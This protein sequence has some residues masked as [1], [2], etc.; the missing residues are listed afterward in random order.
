MHIVDRLALAE[1]APLWPPLLAVRTPGTKSLAHRHHSMHI[2]LALQGTLRCRAEGVE[3]DGAGV[4]TAPDVDHELDAQGVEVLIVFLEPESR[5]G[6]ALRAALD[7]PVRVI[8]AH[9]RDLL[10][11][12]VH[13]GALMR[14]EGVAFSMRAAEVLGR[15]GVEP[16]SV[17]PGVRRALAH[18][19]A[20]EVDDDASLSA[21]AAIAK[22]S[23]GRFMHVF[24]ESLGIP[25]RPYLA[26]LKLQR[27]AVALAS[28]RPVAEAA[29]AAGFA[30][31]A[32]M[33]RSF[34]RM[35]GLRPSDIAARL[36][37][38]TAS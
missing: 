29:H 32:H 20:A 23:P 21:L 33:S 24:T 6:R 18:L 9:E 19:K 38:A 13:P 14:H 12:D 25:L 35:L 1:A 36:R 26:W 27:A 17:H 28:G 11:A 22:L 4:L 5:A 16:P 10:C 2:V 8:D 37:D 31:A 34:V 15:G 30:D 3:H 7:G